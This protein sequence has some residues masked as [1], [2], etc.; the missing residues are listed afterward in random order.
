MG[1]FRRNAFTL[2]ELLIVIG[3]I[4]VLIAVLVPALSS[5]NE[6][7]KKT[8]CLANTKSI[9][10]ALTVYAND[11]DLRF[12]HWSGWHVYQQEGHPDDQPGKGWTELIESYVEGSTDVYVDPARRH[13]NASFAYFLSARYVYRQREAEFTSLR[14][15]EVRLPS[16][17]VLCGDCNQPSLFPKPYGTRD[18]A[19]DCDKDDATQPCCL[20]PG[21]LS[22]HRGDSN[23]AFLDGHAKA[24][25][26]FTPGEMT[27]HA[28]KLLGWELDEAGT[29]PS[30]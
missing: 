29:G 7:A 5:A 11:H 25:S 10:M 1:R 9:A 22:P 16:N 14:Q 27:F 30:K 2:V 23:I 28:R 24:Y 21:E 19:P 13:E 26:V 8:G 3:V 12:P 20:F 4:G 6:A 15:T 17:F 18:L